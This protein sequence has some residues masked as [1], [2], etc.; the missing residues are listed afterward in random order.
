MVG[1]M[2]YAIKLWFYTASPNLIIILGIF[3]EIAKLILNLRLL[4]V[5]WVIWDD[6]SLFLEQKT[7]S[8][9]RKSEFHLFLLKISLAVSPQ[10]WE[11]KGLPC[12]L[13]TFGPG[14]HPILRWP[15]GQFRVITIANPAWRH[16]W[17]GGFWAGQAA[18]HKIAWWYN[19]CVSGPC[20]DPKFCTTLV[21]N[22]R[23]GRQPWMYC[24]HSYQQQKLST[25]CS[26]L[27]QHHAVRDC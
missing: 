1:Y 9:S 4:L 3:L 13:T 5:I 11:E 23:G 20:R 14:T 25:G 27:S 22:L 7:S 10:I 18:F 15:P 16:D 2:E 17:A 8:M 12:A 26:V 6:A 24:L 19:N 21:T